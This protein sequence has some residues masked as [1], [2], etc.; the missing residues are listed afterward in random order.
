MESKKSS[1]TE[2]ISSHISHTGISQV[3]NSLYFEHS[4]KSRTRSKLAKS[5]NASK[6]KSQGSLSRKREGNQGTEISSKSVKD[7][8]SSSKK[9]PAEKQHLLTTDSLLETY[10]KAY[11]VMES[12][13]ADLDDNTGQ[14]LKTDKEEANTSNHSEKLTLLEFR[15]R[16]VR[17]LVSVQ[18]S[19]RKNG[20][21]F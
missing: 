1:D 9:K 11:R 7:S 15:Q 3:N 13:F 20:S 4:V 16:V 6:S 21:T 5:A 12:V 18:Q 19:K 2:D 8:A 10:F 17:R 14:I